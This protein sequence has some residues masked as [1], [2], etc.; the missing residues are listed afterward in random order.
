MI[1]ASRR[2][3]SSGYP[4]QP[5]LFAP[6]ARRH[7]AVCL[8]R[9]RV[10]YYPSRCVAQKIAF[11]S[12]FTPLTFLGQK[13]FFSPYARAYVR[14]CM[15]VCMRTHNS[16]AHRAKKSISQCGKHCGVKNTIFTLT[17][18]RVGEGL[19][20]F[21]FLSKRPVYRPLAQIHSNTTKKQK[22]RTA[23]LRKLYHL[24]TLF[25]NKPKG[26]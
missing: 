7:T 26:S 12:S 24:P 2:F 9:R 3:A 15:H 21:C 20:E 8:Y 19:G 4:L 14:V 13:Y 6:T 22:L 17:F 11:Y 16:R 25:L 23:K 18:E 1:W 5:R 10:R